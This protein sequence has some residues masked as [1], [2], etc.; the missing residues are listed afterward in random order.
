MMQPIFINYMYSNW[1]IIKLHIHER[2]VL[3]VSLVPFGS[4]YQLNLF[5]GL[6]LICLSEMYCK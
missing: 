5:N 1:H 6:A 2:R 3:H 4:C